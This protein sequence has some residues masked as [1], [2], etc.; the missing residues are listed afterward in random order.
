M[1][2]LAPQLAS[3]QTTL[4]T[5]TTFGTSPPPESGKPNDPC[6]FSAPYGYI[7][8]GDITFSALVSSPAGGVVSAEF[9][10]VPSDGSA[11][12]DLTVDAISGTTALLS[13]PRSYFS[14]GV[15]Y[16]WQVRE[17]DSSGNVSPY[18]RACHFISDQT[19]PPEPMVSS[20]TF[21]STTEPP[22]GTL[23]T[24]TFSV[25]G[26][27]VSAVTGFEYGLNGGGGL[28]VAA[29]ADGSATTPPLRSIQPGSNFITVE[30]IDHGG[31]VSQQVTYSFFLGPQPPAA[32]KD[33]NGDGFP[34]LLTV[35]GTPGLAPGLW[36]AT[37]KPKNSAAADIGQLNLPATDI[38]I[39]GTQPGAVGSGPSQYD[40][41]QV[42]TGQFYGEGFQD[43][44]VYFPSGN[45]AGGGVVIQGSGDG[46]ALLSASEVSIPAV[47]LADANGDSPIQLVNAY[48]SIYGTGLP[49]LLATNGDP[50]NEVISC[51]Q[52]N[53]R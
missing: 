53:G 7:G 27:D 50:V 23:G 40:G 41:A 16:A 25:S 51:A 8:F 12:L 28:F 43:V 31:N 37:G 21:N 14:N 11:P 18:T 13:V 45:D 36:L 47:L 15:T 1:C 24:F 6:G 49:D 39:N 20:A 29:G 10:I 52:K 4:P 44:L 35:G 2:L 48:G 19:V 38:G 3:A 5:P 22:A 46:S 34:D 26:P 30:T 32:D 17:T 33:M 9:L 42:I